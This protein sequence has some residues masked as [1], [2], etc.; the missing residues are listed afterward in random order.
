MKKGVPMRLRHKHIWV[1]QQSGIGEFP[2]KN[3]PEKL[4]C[5]GDLCQCECGKMMFFPHDKNLRPVE[6]E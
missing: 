6:A 3:T 1:Y 4:S 5:E 2:K